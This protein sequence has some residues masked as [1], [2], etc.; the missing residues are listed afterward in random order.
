V[1]VVKCS[2]DIAGHSGRNFYSRDASRAS[3]VERLVAGNAAGAGVGIAIWIEVLL[4]NLEA[5]FSSRP[6]YEK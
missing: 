1:E 2:S 6:T 4:S 3:N 5:R